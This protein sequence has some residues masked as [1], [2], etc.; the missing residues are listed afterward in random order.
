MLQ[1]PSDQY[2]AHDLHVMSCCGTWQNVTESTDKTRRPPSRMQL[3]MNTQS[4]LRVAMPEEEV[5]QLLMNTPTYGFYSCGVGGVGR[6]EVGKGWGGEGRMRFTAA[7][8]QIQQL[9]T[10]QLQLGHVH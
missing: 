5:R 8:Q 9:S 6:M 7:V 10:T 3:N 2:L 1:S 4:V